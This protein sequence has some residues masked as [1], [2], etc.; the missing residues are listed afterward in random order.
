MITDAQSVAPDS[1]PVTRARISVVVFPGPT[2]LS[3]NAS[4]AARNTPSGSMPVLT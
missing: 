2:A 3:A 4:I 1:G